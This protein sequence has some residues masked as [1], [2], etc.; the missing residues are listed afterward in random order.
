MRRLETDW[1][2][3]TAW[4]DLASD[5]TPEFCGVRCYGIGIYPCSQVQ[6]LLPRVW[7][8]EV[9]CGAFVDVTSRPDLASMAGDDTVGGGETHACADEFT[10]RVQTLK[11]TKQ[12]IGV[13]RVESGTVIANKEYSFAIFM[14]GAKLNKRRI[15]PRSVFP[16]IADEVFEDNLHQALVGKDM[17]AACEVKTEM[18]SVLFSLKAGSDGFNDMTEI[19]GAAVQGVAAGTR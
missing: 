5:Y 15:P 19:D 12:A 10:L 14:C 11:R 18:A 2:R 1:N 4:Q 16:S 6:A 7:N 9:E 8:C 17:C 13:T 3:Q